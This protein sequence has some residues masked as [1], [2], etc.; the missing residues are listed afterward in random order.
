MSDK[1]QTK[2]YSLDVQALGRRIREMREERRWSLREMAQL[3]GISHSS[4]SDLERA[5]SLSPGLDT[6]VAIARVLDTSLDRLVGLVPDSSEENKEAI[7]K[8]T[9]AIA[10]SLLDGPRLTTEALILEFMEFAKWRE[11]RER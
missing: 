7:H 5:R 11:G 9:N 4:I 6:L 1:I 8:I 3:S 2:S 10:R